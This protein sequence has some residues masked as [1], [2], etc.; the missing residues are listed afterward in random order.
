MKPDLNTATTDAH[1]MWSRV[2]RLFRSQGER[3]SRFAHG[4]RLRPIRVGLR[5]QAHEA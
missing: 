5:E 2:G 1:T 3:E 4:L